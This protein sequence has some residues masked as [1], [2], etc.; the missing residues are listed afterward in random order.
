MSAHL[1]YTF[2]Y[3]RLNKTGRIMGTRAACVLRACGRAG[4]VQS[5]CL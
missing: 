1:Y 4:G 2:L 5:I 3:A